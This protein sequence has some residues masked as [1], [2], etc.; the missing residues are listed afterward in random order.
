MCV[1]VSVAQLCEYVQ[2][3]GV[4]V[5]V[6]LRVCTVNPGTGGD[7]ISNMTGFPANIYLI[8]FSFQAKLTSLIAEIAPKTSWKIN[9]RVF[10]IPEWIR[11]G[12]LA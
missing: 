11:S 4:C 3:E 5:C 10:E 2:S 12:C 8:F 1:S 9:S 7:F 6:R